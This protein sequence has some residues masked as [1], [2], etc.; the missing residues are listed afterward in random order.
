VLAS[1][2]SFDESSV[3]R[4]RRRSDSAGLLPFERRFRD[5]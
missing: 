3:D 1:L 2:L 5:N 4:R